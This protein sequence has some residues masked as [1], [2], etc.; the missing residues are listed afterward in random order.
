MQQNNQTNILLETGTN[1]LEIME[2]TVGGQIFGINVAKVKEI[3][4]SSPVV[5]M[6]KAHPVI[7]GVFKPR[8]QVITVIDL[9][10]YLELA[11][12]EH[13]DKDIFII[14]SFN[15]QDFAFHVHTVVGIDRISWTMMQKPDQIIYG[16]EEGVATAIAQYQNRLITILDFEK[17]VMEIG[18][19]S[20]IQYSDM[21]RLGNRPTVDA[22]IVVVEDS[23]LLAKMIT[24]SLHKAGYV[25][26]TKFNN[27]KEAWNYLA[28]V[29]NSGDPL[30]DHVTCVITDIEMPQ[31]D[32]H[33][34][35]KLIKDDPVL[36]KLPVVLFSSLID[37]EMRKKGEQ[38]GADEQ[39]TKPE[40]LGLVAIID[41]L[42]QPAAAAEG[43]AE[44]S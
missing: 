20:G 17:I 15:Q 11:P 1:E 25:N 37:S 18:P 13:P 27:G 4:M 16:G 30:A 29:K 22:P 3:M 40:I 2:F 44:A 8:D 33:H 26:I 41:R 31:M 10:K 32:G 43:A 6:Q 42:T 21:G 36:K 19:Q 9:G 39:L 12:S 35:T 14:T 23:M 24:E 7:E 28:E 34:L 5:P 38:V